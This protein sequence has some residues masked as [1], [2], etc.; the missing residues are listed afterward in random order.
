M[1]IKN[2]NYIGFAT[3]EALV[4]TC[5]VPAHGDNPPRLVQLG[6]PDRS[7][8]AK[9]ADAQG[10]HVEITPKGA[11]VFCPSCVQGFKSLGSVM[12]KEAPGDHS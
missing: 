1:G 12:F 3:K 2:Q 5:T 6:K 4:L 9:M 7:Q 8:F 10:W 11:A